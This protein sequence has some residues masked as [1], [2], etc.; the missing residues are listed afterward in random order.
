M[1][2]GKRK[3]KKATLFGEPRSKVIKRP[4]AFKRKA[5][6]AGMST[7]AYARKERHAPGRT[8]KQARLALAF[9]T[10]RKHKRTK[11]RAAKRTGRR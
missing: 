3:A 1:A 9:A 4:G 7:A 10:M 6:K 2:Y 8:G 5:K 11:K